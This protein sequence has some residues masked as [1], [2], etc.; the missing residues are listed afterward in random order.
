M[1]VDKST[2]LEATRL[3]YE[4]PSEMPMIA[5]LAINGKLRM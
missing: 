3:G 4:R 1:Y 2:A 5:V